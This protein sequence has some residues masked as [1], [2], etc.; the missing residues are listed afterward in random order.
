MAGLTDH[1]TRLA[2]ASQNGL[3]YV[4]ELCEMLPSQDDVLFRTDR[5]CVFGVKRTKWISA[6]RP[7][8]LDECL[9]PVSPA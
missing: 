2:Y 8:C 7:V 4:L 9:I 5:L 3:D 6:R 1:A